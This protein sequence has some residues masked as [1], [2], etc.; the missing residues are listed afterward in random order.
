MNELRRGL[1]LAC[2]VCGSR[3]LFKRFGLFDM[4]QRCPLCG[5]NFERM[6]GHFLGA[7]ALN[8]VVSAGA[9]LSTICLTIVIAGTDVSSKLLLLT[10]LPMATILPVLFDPFSRTLWTAIDILIR[11]VE[12][13]ELN[14]DFQYNSSNET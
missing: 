2:A 10:A 14:D 7:V 9:V 4:R 3:H 6:E 5:I 13:K 1:S 12:P 8:T 11:P